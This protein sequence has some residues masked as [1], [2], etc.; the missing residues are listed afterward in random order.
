MGILE[1]GTQL[2]A[3]NPR[4]EG[5][6]TRQPIQ[7]NLTSSELSKS[8]LLLF[9]QEE[10]N[11]HQHVLKKAPWAYNLSRHVASARGS[12]IEVQARQTDYQGRSLA[13]PSPGQP[14]T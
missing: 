10:Y 14:A 3:I 11:V 4:I 9:K 2:S 13:S 6:P 1:S 8:T 12:V 7:H 5:M